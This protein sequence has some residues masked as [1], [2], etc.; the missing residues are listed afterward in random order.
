M[1]QSATPPHIPRFNKSKHNSTVWPAYL[2]AKTQTEHPSPS[3]EPSEKNPMH[4]G[5]SRHRSH[6]LSCFRGKAVRPNRPSSTPLRLRVGPA[7]S[8]PTQVIAMED[9]REIKDPKTK[10]T[11]QN[12][13]RHTRSYQSNRGT[14][15]WAVGVC[16]AAVPDHIIK[17]QINKHRTFKPSL[18]GG[19]HVSE[20]RRG[21]EQSLAICSGR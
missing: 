12:S 4:G 7:C 8:R 17:Q 6:P 3:P 16:H 2:L 20:A 13:P 14:A 18:Y 9:Q 5:S 21:L 10:G 19:L 15:L 1:S 11:S